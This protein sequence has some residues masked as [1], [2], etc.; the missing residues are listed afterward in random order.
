MAQY[1]FGEENKIRIGVFDG[2]PGNPNDP[3][4]INLKLNKEEGALFLGEWEHKNKNFRILLGGFKYSE[5]SAPL[6]AGNS[7]RNNGFYGQAELNPDGK[8][9]WFLRLGSADSKINLLDNY[10]GAGLVITGPFANRENDRFGIAFARA[11][12]GSDA[13][14]VNGLD[15]DNETNI[16][17]TYSA[18]FA[19][20]ITLQGDIQHIINDGAVISQKD[21]T[22]IGLRIRYEFGSN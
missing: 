18:P 19:S 4:E 16:E 22:V 9:A 13:R 11:G 7:K 12:I 15:Y 6:L 1:R 20:G 8:F 2:V 14:I 17:L 3:N 5:T 10:I 21:A